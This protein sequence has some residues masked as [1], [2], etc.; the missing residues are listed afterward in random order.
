MLLD[1][2]EFSN[3]F[4]RYP[5]LVAGFDVFSAEDAGAERAAEVHAG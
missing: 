2:S 4:R 1:Y 5:V 3:K